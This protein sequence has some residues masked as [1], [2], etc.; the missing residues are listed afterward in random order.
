MLQI[1]LKVLFHFPMARG[2]PHKNSPRLV[3]LIWNNVNQKP[4]ATG[5]TLK[6]EPLKTQDYL[7]LEYGPD[8]SKNLITS[9]FGQALPA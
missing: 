4:K 6:M 9:T 3:H 5:N 1:F 7:Y 2:Y 8:L